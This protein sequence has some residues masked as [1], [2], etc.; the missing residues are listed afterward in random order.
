MTEGG[1]YEVSSIQEILKGWA[2]ATTK[3]VN[4]SAAQDGTTVWEPA[5]GKK[6]VLV[7]VMFSTDT[8]MNVSVKQGETTIIP[9]V[10][11]AANGGSVVSGGDWPIWVG[12]AD[13]ALTFTSSASGN[14]S[15]M[16][17]GYEM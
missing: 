1:E 8:Q 10:Y 11:L 5:S 12:E 17:Y 4:Y 2:S 13:Q 6:I 3:A 7:G 15:C 14:H 9:P 16:L